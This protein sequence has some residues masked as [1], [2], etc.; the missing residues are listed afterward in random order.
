MTFMTL[1]SRYSFHDIDTIYY[2]LTSAT[3]KQIEN[4]HLNILYHINIRNDSD[5]NYSSYLAD[6][7]IDDRLF[8]LYYRHFLFI[9]FHI[10]GESVRL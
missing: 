1:G 7:K 2:A 3:S 5:Q 10:Q 9:K 4:I 8:L 6:K